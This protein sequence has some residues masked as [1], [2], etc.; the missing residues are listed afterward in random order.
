MAAKE[1]KERNPESFRDSLSA[2]GR[3]ALLGIAQ[4]QITFAWI[5]RP[6]RRARK[7]PDQ[8][9]SNTLGHQLRAKRLAKGLREYQLAELLGV[10]TRLVKNWEA[11]LGTPS[12]AVLSILADLLGLTESPDTRKPAPE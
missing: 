10:P 5:A 9:A 4:R 11:N 12:Q 8:T 2:L 3:V 1:R 6:A 7:S